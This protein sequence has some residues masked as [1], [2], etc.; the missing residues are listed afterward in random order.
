MGSYQSSHVFVEPLG[1]GFEDDMKTEKFTVIKPNDDS[2]TVQTTACWACVGRTRRLIRR[3]EEVVR[4]HKIT[5]LSK[6]RSFEREE[7]AKDELRAAI[8]NLEYV[9]EKHRLSTSDQD[10][11][12]MHLR[13]Q[14]KDAHQ[15]RRA[16]QLTLEHA[17]GRCA[18]KLRATKNLEKLSDEAKQRTM[19]AMNMQIRCALKRS[20]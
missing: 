8:E 5:E 11:A 13:R 17:V 18:R 16:A 6:L 1:Y 3:E 7:A 14:L 15:R 2:K 20:R 19:A 12:P 4:Q 10:K 9:A